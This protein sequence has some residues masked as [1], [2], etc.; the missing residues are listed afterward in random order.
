LESAEGLESAAGLDSGGFFVQEEG[1]AA[2]MAASI[3]ASMGWVAST[4]ISSFVMALPGD[5]GATLAM[6]S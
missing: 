4:G 5:G 1:G 3:S 6:G 2:M